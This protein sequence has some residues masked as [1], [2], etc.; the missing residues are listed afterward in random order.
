MGLFLQSARPGE[1]HRRLVGSSRRVIYRTE[2]YALLDTE[3]LGKE[4]ISKSK[5]EFAQAIT[6]GA[7]GLPV[8]K[9]A[10]QRAAAGDR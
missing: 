10:I 7:I 2:R 3:I 9:E 1:N 8:I 6:I 5:N 4:Y